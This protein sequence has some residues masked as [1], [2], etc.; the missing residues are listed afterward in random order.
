MK[1]LLITTGLF[2]GFLVMPKLAFGQSCK[3]Q[4]ALSANATAEIRRI[5]TTDNAIR[6]TLRLPLLTSAQVVLVTDTAVCSR[7]RLALD[8]MITSTTPDAINLGPRPIYAIRVGSF[9]AAINPGS[10]AGEFTPIFFF[11]DNLSFLRI[12]LF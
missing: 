8:S 4:D 12:L 6:D 2:A 10:R 1:H 5:A 7:V 3:P 11:N 9:Y